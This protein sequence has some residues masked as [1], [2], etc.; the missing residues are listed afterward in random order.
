MK[1][2]H[3]ILQDQY[4]FLP[5]HLLQKNVRALSIVPKIYIS[6]ILRPILFLHI[7]Y[8]YVDISI[9]YDIYGI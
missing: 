1:G 8:F 5:V 6:L 3:Y 4:L 2:H 7:L 9:Y